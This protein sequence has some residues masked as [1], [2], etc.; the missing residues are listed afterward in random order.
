MPSA[1]PCLKVSPLSSA[2]HEY[3]PIRSSAHLSW[4]HER[5]SPRPC[6]VWPSHV[7]LRREFGP[8]LSKIPSKSCLARSQVAQGREPRR[9]GAVWQL[10]RAACARTGTALSV[11]EG[12]L[13]R[14]PRKRRKASYSA[15]SHAHGPCQSMRLR[16]SAPWLTRHHAFILLR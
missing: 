6:R 13:A 15:R 7:V 11:V 3:S 9:S 12:L 2:R 16:R 5:C 8:V 14:D 4:C 1:A 10:A